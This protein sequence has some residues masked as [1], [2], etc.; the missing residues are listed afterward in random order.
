MK[1]AWFGMVF[2]SILAGCGAPAAGDAK[3]AADDDE[4]EAEL[5]QVPAPTRATFRYLNRA[6]DAELASA[7]VSATGRAAIA[8]VLTD[9]AF[10]DEH[11][12]E[13]ISLSQ[14]N[15]RR[16]L[17]AAAATNPAD[18]ACTAESPRKLPT[19]FVVTPDAG[20]AW[21]LSLIDEAKRSIAIV[22]YEFSAQSVRD[23][24]IR[25]R[26]RG[27]EV[28]VILDRT[29]NDV[30]S[31]LSEFADAGIEAKRSA[32]AFTY[33]HQKTMVIDG[34][35]LV[36]FSGN[37]DIQSFTHGR[38][39]AAIT[40][41][42]EDVWDAEDLFESD[43]GTG[44]SDPTCTRLVAAPSNAKPRIVALIDGATE[45]LALEA[46]YASDPAVVDAVVRAKQRGVRVRVL[47]NDPAFGVGDATATAKTLIGRGIPVRRSPSLFIHAKLLIA[48]GKN[49]F[50]GS[51]NF[52]T[53]SL[54]HN[55][56]LGVIVALP[57]AASA[58]LLGVFER[59]F[60]AGVD[61]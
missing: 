2:G 39:F 18:D 7:G 22:M 56:E 1:H 54:E 9:D 19:R 25:A 55:R 20:D 50:V 24:L 46:L 47:F 40:R 48:D 28:R 21:L 42:P 52:S 59:D 29:R 13:A 23:A 32:T 11:E 27:V 36:V 10:H 57:K 35:T 43:W 31:R 38:N 45:D 15:R 4:N 58:S 6:T 30:A 33:T 12:L 17:A 34:E 44:G 37:F 60:T 8:R 26:A 49:V 14:R 3:D 5:V 51:E 61:F 53:N 41:E 16:V